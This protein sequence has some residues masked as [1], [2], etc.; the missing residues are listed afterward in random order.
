MSAAPSWPATRGN[1]VEIIGSDEGYL[2]NQFILAR[3]NQRNNEYGGD[4]FANQMQL[5]VE[6]VRDTRKA[7]GRDYI[8][9]A[10]DPLV[11]QADPS[12]CHPRVPVPQG[13]APWPAKCRQ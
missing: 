10:R 9:R 7:C 2:I 8:I 13:R 3:T 11:E 12:I 5:A 1:R 4:R 6:I